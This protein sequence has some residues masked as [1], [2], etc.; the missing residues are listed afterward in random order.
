[1][2]S[3]GKKASMLTT[4][5]KWT[6]ISTNELQFGDLLNLCVF[7]FSLDIMGAVDSMHGFYAEKYV[8]I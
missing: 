2:G 1:M 3:S 5:L 4:A 8:W 7:R 6:N